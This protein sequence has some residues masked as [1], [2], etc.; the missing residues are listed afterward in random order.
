MKRRSTSQPAEQ[1]R[2]HQPDDP[3]ADER[4]ERLLDDVLREV[5]QPAAVELKARVMAAIDDA[6]RRTTANERPAWVRAWRPAVAFGAAAALVI[7]VLA[8]LWPPGTRAPRQ[9]RAGTP[10]PLQARAEAPALMQ[11]AAGTPGTRETGAEITVLQAGAGTPGSLRSRA[12]AATASTAA[13]VQAS[14]QV[15]EP[16]T[17]PHLPGAPAGD[18][19]DPLAPMPAPPAIA[20]API[21]QGP[22]ASAPPVSDMSRPVTDF[23]ADTASSDVPVRTTGQ[24]GGTRR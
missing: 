14:P 1:V 9:Q 21:A 13:R 18:L 3:A 16:A 19:G 2:V 20:F 4:R 23:P 17:G 10:A 22:I 12:R 6:G 11:P 15:E 8:A 5:A 24:S 7:V